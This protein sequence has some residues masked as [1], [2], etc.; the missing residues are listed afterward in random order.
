MTSFALQKE[1]LGQWGPIRLG[2][3]ILLCPKSSEKEAEATARLLSPDCQEV[4][5]GTPSLGLECR[6]GCRIWD[7][8]VK[9]EHGQQL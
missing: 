2:D 7:I 8:A 9:K 4:R 1:Q 5:D 6:E 3:I